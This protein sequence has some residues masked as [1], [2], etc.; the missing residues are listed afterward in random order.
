MKSKLSLFLLL[1]LLIS[2]SLFAQSNLD[3]PI[4]TDP[5]VKVGKLSNGLTYYI[6][7]N[8]KPEKKVEFRLAI[9]AGSI[10]EREDQQGYA[11]FL[12]H[13]AFNGS[14]NFKKNELVSYLQS[15]GVNFGADLNAYT[16]FDET[17]Y[18]LSIPTEK[19]E[20]IDKG[21]LVMKDWAS[22]LTLDPEE[23][24]KEQGVVLE[25]LRLGKGANQRMRDKYYPKLLF[26][27]Q[28]ANRLPIGKKELLENVNHQA[29]VD[30][31]EDWYRPDLMALIIVGDVDVDQIENKIKSQFSDIKAKRP[32]KPRP[33]YDVPNHK[34]T[35]VA[36][37]T[38]KESTGTS[39]SLYFKRPPTEI[40]TLRDSRNSILR[41]LYNGMLAAR[42][43][44]IRQTPNSPFISGG[45][46]FSSLVRNKGSYFMGGSTTPENLKQTITTLLTENKR[47]QEFGFTQAELE[48]QKIRLLTSYESRYKERDK[49]DS[50]TFADTYVNSFLSQN[51]SA[52][53]EFNFDLVKK[54]LPEI[55]L[56]EIN[57]LSKD[58]VTDENRVIVVTGIEKDGTKYPNE[59]EILQLVAE[60]S[61][62]KVT[63]YTE[64]VA[65]E[66]LVGELPKTAKVV[67]EKTNDKFGITYWTLSNGVK[68]VL[69]PTNFKADQIIMNGFSPGGFSSY[70]LNKTINSYLLGRLVNESGL[71]NIS[72]VELNKMLAGKQA[73]VS[74]N[75]GNM[76][77]SING[78]ASP[79]DFE[80]MLQLA[81]A[82]LTNVNFDKTVFD[83]FINKQ[84]MSLSMI[85]SNPQI[86]FLLETLRISNSNDPRYF[87]PIDT[88][89]FE[90]GNFET[91]KEIYKDRFADASDFTFIFVGNFENENVKPL[92]TKYLGNLPNINR[93]ENWKD[94]GIRP[95]KEPI[96][97]IIYKGLDEKSQV[98][99][100]FTGETTY[101]RDEARDFS[102]LGELLTI[103]L[104]E[105]LREE[106]GGVYGASAGG[107]INKY[108][109]GRYGFTVGFSCG[110]ENV[111]SLIEATQKEIEKL[112]NGEIDEKDIAKIKEARIVK[113]KEQY[114]DNS[115]WNSL[116]F[117]N[118]TQDLEIL[119]FAEME[120][121][122]SQITKDGLQ[123]VAQKYLNPEHKKQFVLMPE[124]K[125]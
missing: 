83:S 52:G 44:E 86:Y 111:E 74:L 45:G 102:A 57:A 2:V 62:A 33:I 12:E 24:K 17:V 73:N 51:P 54:L 115:Y 119:D 106:K 5:Q 112:R 11:H 118:L 69:R 18:M 29:L 22:G 42:L 116:I 30:F 80:T 124:N 15:I 98:S 32:I 19:S 91:I 61:K 41:A 96:N 84:K 10:L 93:K 103:K 26:G 110:P 4:P 13:M 3:I 31:Y 39:T 82:T 125:K 100:S 64:N 59:Q 6:R 114:K 87:S 20:V 8:T 63:P 109:F 14:K 50:W 28:Y 105:V 88:K 48:R 36:I 117:A 25:E 72:K 76:F 9:N 21:L 97:E 85:S 108:P 70:D 66:P 23:I 53:I 81:Y 27:S 71:G 7:R 55:T 113:L 90:A 38:D 16:S 40:K 95:I 77:E 122:S 34:E 37:E 56:N 35:F 123:K 99:I 67:E 58:T 121:R 46:G 68:V 104:I 47:V 75:V 92:I 120:A 101:N 43:D 65:T 1:T 94:D 49:S 89:T 79:K 60:A 78:G 107:A